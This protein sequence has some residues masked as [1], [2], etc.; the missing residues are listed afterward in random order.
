MVRFSYK[1]LWYDNDLHRVMRHQWESVEEVNAWL[2]IVH[3]FS[4]RRISRFPDG[5]RVLLIKD[6]PT[7][8]GPDWFVVTVRW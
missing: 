3:R 2:N 4:I 8:Y 7:A 5:F 1:A 6:A